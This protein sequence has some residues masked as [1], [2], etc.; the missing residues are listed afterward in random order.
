MIIKAFLKL[1]G[2]WLVIKARFLVPFE[3]PMQVRS[4]AISDIF[5][6]VR[7]REVGEWGSFFRCPMGQGH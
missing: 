3:G 5:V 1:V 2:F 6:V 4:L 7:E